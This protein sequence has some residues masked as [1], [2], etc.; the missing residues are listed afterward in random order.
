MKNIL[1]R[2][3]LLVL[4]AG[5]LLAAPALWSCNTETASTKVLREHEEKM[6]RIDEDTIRN[7]LTRNNLISTATRTNSGLYLV[8]IT[9][10]TGIP[11][12]N[13]KRVRMKYIG[14][15]LSNGA[16]P[17]SSGY[18]ASFGNPSFPQGSI[19]DNSADKGTT[20]GCAVFT[21][22]DP[23]LR[24]GFN[25]GLLLMRTG[26]R[27]LLLLPSRLAYGPAGSTG[28]PPDSALMFDVEVLEV[29]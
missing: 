6:T 28:I 4:L 11:V 14:R 25:E 15:F 18:P 19:F 23:L 24:V 26:D 3:R 5:L 2:S 13:N 27:K 16:Q 7:Y 29:F 12:T 22:G 9:T 20:C 21:T 17:G 1:L 8:P 10:G